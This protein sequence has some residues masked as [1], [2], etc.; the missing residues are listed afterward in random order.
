[1]KPSFWMTALVVTLLPR[2]PEPVPAW[3]FYGHRLINRQAVFSLPPPLFS[4]FK[5]AIDY[6]SDHAVDA[7]KRRYA[8]PHEAPRHYLD[9]DRY[10]SP[11][12]PDLPR[13]WH[14]AMLQ[15][16]EWRFVGPGPD[17][18]PLFR[19]P[20]TPSDSLVEWHPLLQPAHPAP[21]TRRELSDW[22]RKTALPRRFETPW[23]V[24]QDSLPAWLAPPTG[25][26]SDLLLTDR[27]SEHGI[28]P[29]HLSHSLSQL[30]DAFRNHD[31]SR[32]LRL[33]ADMGHYIADAHVPLHTTEN[34]NGQLTGQT[35]IHAFWES[36]LP[37]LFAE[38]AYDFWIRPAIF[39]QDADGFFWQIILDSH[40]LVDSVLRTERLLRQEFP[41]DRQLCFETRGRTVVKV[42]CED[43]SEAYHRRLGNMVEIRMRQAIRAV[44]SAWYT[45]W[46]L[47]GQPDLLSGQSPDLA[48]ADSTWIQW[49]QAYQQ[50]SIQGRAHPD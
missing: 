1:M 16:T 20:V 46:V 39:L 41:A 9:L 40:A 50:G 17:T 48:G 35:G 3:G 28:L 33:A 26:T 36:R 34:Y 21:P 18:I 13:Q 22:F 43:F 5:P 19:K 30:T 8:S 23:T 27:L 31:H 4:Y 37:E 49:Q 24:P 6:L 15:M 38:D 11:P 29:Y 44:A 10:G 45:A 25:W 2:Q 7:D 42:P 47:A 32:I 12:F 14:D